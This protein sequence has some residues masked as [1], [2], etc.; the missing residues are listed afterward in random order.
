MPTDNRY[1]LA[2]LMLILSGI[3]TCYLHDGAVFLYAMFFVGVGLYASR[4]PTPTPE[5]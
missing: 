5:P 2:A 3:I 1:R 4:N